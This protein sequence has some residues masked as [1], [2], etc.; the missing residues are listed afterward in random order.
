[1]SND[2][3]L[4][5]MPPTGNLNLSKN[6][7]GVGEKDL[8]EFDDQPTSEEEQEIDAIKSYGK[9][10]TIEL[11]G[12]SETQPAVKLPKFFFTFS[13]LEKISLFAIA[14]ALII[15]S[16]LAIIHFSKQIPAESEISKKVSLPVNGKILS[17]TSMETYWRSPDKQSD[18]D[19]IV[20]R[21]VILIPTIKIQVSGSSGA[22]R[23]FFRD[24]DG[25]LVGDS[26]TLPISGK[27]T[28]TISATDG[29]ADMG[30]H[31]SYRTGEDRPWI[32][33]ALEG[34]SVDAPIEKFKTLF[35]TEIS[36]QIR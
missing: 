36:T 12:N 6:L 10:M 24:S 4:P 1:M 31:A 5:K 23:V 19:D 32:A 21:G 15:C 30:M 26:T 9:M 33:Q 11:P 25:S 3:N 7:I 16:A 2:S 22:I 18:K 14:S 35:K 28:L 34:P 8:W 13:K 20:Q 17:V 29:F 27:E